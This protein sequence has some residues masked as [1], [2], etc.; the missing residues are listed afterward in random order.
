MNENYFMG[1]DGFVWF[2]GVVEDRN[3]PEKLGRV[4]V[5][6]L[7]WHSESLVNIPKSDLPWA[8][9][10]HP[11]TDPSMQGLGNTPSF[12]VEGSWVVG[13]FLDAVEK[14]QPL[15]IGSLPG[16]PTSVAD[17]TRGFGD[18][19]AKY[20]SEKI[21]HSNHS[22]N[23]PDTN[24]LA[25]G[26]V[27]ETHKS[28]ERRRKNKLADV[29]TAGKPGLN[30]SQ[31]FST[32][33]A[34][35]KWSEP[36]PKSVF[37]DQDPY[38]SAK[39]PFNHVQESESG[40]VFEIDDT[41][42]NERLYREHM[43]GTFEEI[44]PQGTRVTKVVYDDYEI[45]AR[46]KKIVIN[47]VGK[48]AK[49]GNPSGAL[50]LTVYGSVR[51]YVDGDYTLDITGNYIRRVGL[52]EIVKIGGKKGEDGNP[53]GGNM[54]TEIVNGS[55]NLSVDKNYIATIG[56]ILGDITTTVSGNETRTV[57]GTQ[58]ITVT[59]DISVTSTTASI[60]QT[61]LQDFGVIALNDVSIVA[62]NETSHGSGSNVTI[63]YEENVTETI[64][65]TLSQSVTGAV[66]ET[67]SS[68]LTTKISGVTGIKYSGDATHHYVGAF[69]EKIDGD[70][71]IDVKGDGA[72]TDH[73]H[74][75]SPARGTGTDEVA[76][77]N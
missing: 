10:M 22:I 30:N 25:Q 1:Q 72:L 48:D 19:N 18:P 43:S 46:N 66:T 4:R 44:H 36:H 8:H 49:T 55:Y 60:V 47:A 20:P 23:E 58:D 13:F 68:S 71:F 53:I 16:K 65:G 45:I 61:A 37:S 7:G 29:P 62:G 64:G 5:R 51:Q 59:S 21:T 69:K 54:E 17:A 40:H 14:Q 67:Y 6:C 39:Y 63:N 56:Q 3:D 32:P 35:G 73:V 15:I 2:T 26:I 70:T 12:L 11:I 74:P 27:S 42:D 76:P 34:N 31:E 24:R 9:I 38:P 57:G 41:P 52:N 50:D 77:V 75:V 28:L 33:V